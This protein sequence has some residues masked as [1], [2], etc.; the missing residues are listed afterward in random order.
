MKAFEIMFSDL[1]EEAQKRF[2]EFQR[3]DDPED[4]NFDIA[5]IAIVELD[6]GADSEWGQG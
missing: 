4:G 1:S 3:L 2:L 6:E 5:P